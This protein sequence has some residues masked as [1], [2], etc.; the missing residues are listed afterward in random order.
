[1]KPYLLALILAISAQAQTPGTIAYTRAPDGAPPSPVQDVCIVRTDGSGNRCLTTDGY[2]HHPSWSPSADRIITHPDTQATSL[3]MT[4]SAHDL[5][6]NRNLR[7]GPSRGSR[8]R[9]PCGG[10][11]A[12]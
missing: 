2:S 9:Q 7:E 12:G 8:A 4:C 10:R 6:H 11:M 1:V 5:S 3:R